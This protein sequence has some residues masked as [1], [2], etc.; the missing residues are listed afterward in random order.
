MLWKTRGGY[1]ARVKYNPEIDLREFG[2]QFGPGM[3]TAEFIF[4]IND[5]GQWSAD[6]D[7]EFNQ[8]D[9]PYDEREPPPKG[10]KGPFYAQDFSRMQSNTAKRARRLAKPS[11]SV[12]SGRND[13]EFGDLLKEEEHYN[14]TIDFSF[15]YHYVG[16]GDWGD[17]KKYEIAVPNTM[18][19]AQIPEKEMMFVIPVTEIKKK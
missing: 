2:N 4:E 12:D 13:A 10:R 11:W 19:A 14:A 5:A 6:F 15:K 16:T 1:S 7:F 17:Y 18:R 3:L 8:V 9:N